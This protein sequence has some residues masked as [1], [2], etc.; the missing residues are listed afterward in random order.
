MLGQRVRFAA[1]GRQQHQLTVA[2][3]EERLAVG[4]P[5]NDGNVAGFGKGELLRR[6]ARDRLPPQVEDRTIDLPISY[7]NKVGERRPVRRELWANQPRELSEAHER[8][9]PLALR[10]QPI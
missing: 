9:R 7:G 10:L 8:E 4:R 1:V 3:E 6:P 2:S 5:A